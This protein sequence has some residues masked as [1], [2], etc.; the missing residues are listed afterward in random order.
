[1]NAIVEATPIDRGATALPKGESCVLVIFGASGD[2]TRRKL[3]P[4]LYDLACIGCTNPQFD[5]LG[6][7]RTPTTLEEFRTSEQDYDSVVNVNLKGTFFVTQAVVQHWIAVRQVGKIINISSVHEELP[8]A[9]AR[10]G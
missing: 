5:V 9:P 8:T 7:G 10:A 2:L 4:A 3:I 6:I 1:V